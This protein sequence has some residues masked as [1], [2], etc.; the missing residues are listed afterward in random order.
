MTSNFICTPE[1]TVNGVSVDYQTYCE[2]QKT[3]KRRERYYY[4]Q[5]PGCRK[6]FTPRRGDDRGYACSISCNNI[7]LSIR[8][9][10]AV[11]EYNASPNLCKFDSQPILCDKINGRYLTDIKNKIFCNASCSAKYYNKRK[12]NDDTIKKIKDGIIKTDEFG[13]LIHI[14]NKKI[15]KTQNIDGQGRLYLLHCQDA[16]CYNFFSNKRPNKKFCSECKPLHTGGYKQNSSR[17]R[18]GYYH[19]IWCDSSWE[20]A[21]VIYCIDNDISIQRCEETFTYYLDGVKRR[22]HPDFIVNG[23]IVEIKGN[24]GEN[25]ELKKDSVGNKPYQI[26]YRKDIKPI[27]Q[28]VINNYNVKESDIYTLYEDYIP[29]FKKCKDEECPNIIEIISSKKKKLFCSVTCLRKNQRINAIN[30]NKTK[31]NVINNQKFKIA[32]E[33]NPKICSH[34]DCPNIIPYGPNVKT[35]K[36]CS[37]PCSV[38]ARKYKKDKENGAPGGI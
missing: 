14:K 5:N 27:L 22:Y 20:L 9:Q 23:I 6:R 1:Y 15:Y 33:N 36:Y 7:C 32:Y 13:G 17:G 2:H 12:Y 35:A 34:I 16:S 19:N 10:K 11:T 28:Y 21:Y 26:L 3:L 30:R 25:V 37:H 29:S 4:C 24:Q 31:K 18:K 38:L 8:T